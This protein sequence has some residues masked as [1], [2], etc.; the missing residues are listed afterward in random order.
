MSKR[1]EKDVAAG[2]AAAREAYHAAAPA[3]PAPKLAARSAKIKG[4]MGEL[5]SALTVGADPCPGCGNPPHGLM[6]PTRTKGITYVEVGCLGCPGHRAVGSGV[7][8][9]VAAWN[10]G[11]YLDASAAPTRGE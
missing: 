1:T 6:Q 7:S 8:E 4:L 3:E 10:G 9:A 5:S 11:E 2:L